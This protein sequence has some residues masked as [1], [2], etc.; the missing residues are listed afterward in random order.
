MEYNTNK[1]EVLQRV[2]FLKIVFLL[3]IFL[4]ITPAIKLIVRT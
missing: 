1:R 4:P 2:F 3:S